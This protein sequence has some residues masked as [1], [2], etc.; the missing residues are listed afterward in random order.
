MFHAGLPEDRNRRLSRD[1]SATTHDPEHAVILSE[2]AEPAW[3]V[4]LA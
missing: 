1:I 3:A 2:V 4:P